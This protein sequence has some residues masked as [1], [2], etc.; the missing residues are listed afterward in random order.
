[1]LKIYS[2]FSHYLYL[3]DGEISLDELA[4]I[5]DQSTGMLA[6]AFAILITTAS[7]AVG[8]KPTN[9]HTFIILD[10]QER[11]LD[12]C[13]IAT[14]RHFFLSNARTDRGGTVGYVDTE[15][16]ES[17]SETMQAMGSH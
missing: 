3:Y 16:L 8:G 11:P 15:R 12:L 5:Q 17:R 10:L 1:M 4:G 13:T 2:I 9:Y 14:S 7:L 6:I